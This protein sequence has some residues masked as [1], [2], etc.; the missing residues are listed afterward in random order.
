MARKKDEELNEEPL[1]AEEAAKG[2]A[3]TDDDELLPEVTA[4]PTRSGGSCAFGVIVFVFIVIVLGV[5]V[6]RQ[7]EKAQKAADEQRSQD[8]Q[9][10]GTNLQSI[11]RNIASANRRINSDPPDIEG[12]IEALNIAR[13]Q[14]EE[15]APSPAAA[16]ANLGDQLVS[17]NGD[18]R[19]AADAL[20]ARNDEYLEQVASAQQD[21]KS[22]ALAE[23]KPLTTKLSTLATSAQGDVDTPLVAPGVSPV[24]PDEGEAATV[25]EPAA[26]TETE[27]EAETPAEAQTEAKTENP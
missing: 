17:L 21:L 2:E 11:Q 9:F 20:G 7:H 16:T 22:A 1:D 23:V 5:L 3:P 18:I 8:L 13:D 27:A 10:L 24:E 6:Y 19:D 12:A 4:K 26:K 15:L 14:L 25:P